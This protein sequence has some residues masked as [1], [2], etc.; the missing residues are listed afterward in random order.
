MEEWSN[1]RNAG[2]YAAFGKDW[3]LAIALLYSLLAK[4]VGKE[5]LYILNIK[6]NN[7]VNQEIQLEVK[8]GSLWILVRCS[9]H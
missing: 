9:Y 3:M 5:S 2:I 8:P 7:K 1:S 6:F 4:L